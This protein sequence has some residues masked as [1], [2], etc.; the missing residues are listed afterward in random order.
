MDSDHLHWMR[1]AMDMV[2]RSITFL[3]I[4]PT[5][6]LHLMNRQRKHSPRARSQLGVCLSEMEESSRKLGTGQTSYATYAPSSYSTYTRSFLLTAYTCAGYMAR[7]ARSNRRDPRRQDSDA[8]RARTPALRD[9]ALRD[10]RAV[11]HVCICASPDG[12]QGGLLRVR[13]R[14]VRRMR[15][16]ACRQ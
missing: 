3:K 1:M 4:C 2:R 13:E 8:L 14:P 9:D 15:E 10:R 7:R 5:L 6:N 12:D 16:R 11:H